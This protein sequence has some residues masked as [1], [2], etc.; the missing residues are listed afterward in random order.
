MGAMASP[1]GLLL[2]PLGLELL[3]VV[4]GHVRRPFA[5]G[6]GPEGDGRAG[7]GAPRFAGSVGGGVLVPVLVI[8]IV[9]IVLVLVFVV[10][11][12]VFFPA[13]GPLGV[14]VPRLAHG[15]AHLS[16]G[17]MGRQ[18]QQD[19]KQQGKDQARRQAAD[20]L[21][22]HHRQKAGDHAPAH[23]LDPVGPEPA[24]EMK[25]NGIGARP[26]QDVQQGTPHHWQ[27]PQTPQAQGLPPVPP[28]QQQSRRP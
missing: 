10:V 26:K 6:E 17:H 7:C 20:A 24:H 27:Q 4:Q 16:T 1:L 23:A 25:V 2:V 18:G 9:V 12:G 21:H 8:I 28:E 5:A 13:G 15:P 19:H 3:R 22:G 14:V 11:L